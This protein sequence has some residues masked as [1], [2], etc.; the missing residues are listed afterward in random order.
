[1]TEACNQQFSFQI[2]FVE[3]AAAVNNN[4]IWTIDLEE[5]FFNSKPQV[6]CSEAFSSFSEANLFRRFG[7]VYNCLRAFENHKLLFKNFNQKLLF[8][9]K[10]RDITSGGNV[11][12]VNEMAAVSLIN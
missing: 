5:L 7:K 11:H 12:H 4:L 10:I 6:F 8:F 2:F 9:K 1:M 3:I